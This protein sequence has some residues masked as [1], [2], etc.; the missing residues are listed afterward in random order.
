M[1]SQMTGFTVWE[2]DSFFAEQSKQKQ[3]K[4]LQTHTV[5][6]VSS[7]FYEI[8]WASESELTARE[9]LQK[10]LPSFSTT[11]WLNW[12]LLLKSL[13]TGTEITHL[14]LVQL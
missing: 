7:A 5:N 6:D 3:R 1:L 14:Y 12:G 13:V 9:K 11:N 8:S 2:A 4:L 10:V